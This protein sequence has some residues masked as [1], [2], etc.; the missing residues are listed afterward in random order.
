M[1]KVRLLGLCKNYGALKILKEINLEVE[2][3]QFTV[4][5]GPSGCGKSTTLR[6][7]A[8][9]DVASS[10]KILIEGRDVTNLEPRERDISMVFQN[11][12]LY[13]SMNVEQNIGFGLK[14]RKM[15]GPE[16]KEKVLS[17]AKLLEITDLL[18]RK[19]RELSGGQQQ[20]VAIG[21]AIVREP[22]LF[23]F[24]E[25]LSNLDAKLR[26]EMRTEIL[27]LHK[28]LKAT[29]IYVTH[30]Q[31]EAMTM[32]DRIVIM[33]HGQVMQV[34]SPEE[35][36]F[37]PA[38]LMVAAFIG[39]PAMNFVQGVGQSDKTINTIFGPIG[40]D[41]NISQGQ[42]VEIG[43]RPDDFLFAGN[44]RPVENTTLVK[45]SV[46]L[47]EL[48][49][50]RAIIHLD[51]G[52]PKPFKAVVQHEQFRLIEMGGKAAFQFRTSDLHVFDKKTGARL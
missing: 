35:I 31:E 27:G 50:A 30:D 38:T 21:R 40:F 3:G 32:A 49:G 5:L 26:V 14:A 23:L 13:P 15:P 37:R 43:I 29:T 8:G 2:D 20:R 41:G 48:L 24:D 17:A 10:G 11:Y 34:A 18:A 25:P 52:A 39:S 1:S 6:I 44:E 4:L 46:I 33:E 36:Y 51:V 28:R 45:C 42:A 9:L 12:A 22:K 19:P 16:I 47:R 7:I